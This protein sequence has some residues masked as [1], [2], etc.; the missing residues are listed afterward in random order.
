L[1]V[2]AAEVEIQSV[3]YFLVQNCPAAG[4]EDL[5]ETPVQL[6]MRRVDQLV[7]S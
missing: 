5:V 1:Q 3:R 6:A 2:A 7:V 4:P